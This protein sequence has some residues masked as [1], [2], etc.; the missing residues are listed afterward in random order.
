MSSI[1]SNQLI[2]AL[3]YTF[4]LSQAKGT[5]LMPFHSV[6]AMHKQNE[7]L[8]QR[9]ST[10]NMHRVNNLFENDRTIMLKIDLLDYSRLNKSAFRLLWCLKTCFSEVK[11]Q[12]TLI[13]EGKA[14]DWMATEIILSSDILNKIR[15]YW[16]DF[17]VIN[18]ASE[19]LKCDFLD[20][21]I[22]LWINVK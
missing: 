6:F 8:R 17:I 16:I 15:K 3:K 5:S 10:P 18:I 21:A 1:N 13:V 2:T 4:N 22:L 14:T 19:H 20:F 12:M 11:M 9:Q 7:W